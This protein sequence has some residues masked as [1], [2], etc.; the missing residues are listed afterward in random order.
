MSAPYYTC[1]V[2]G[3]TLS[4]SKTWG[5]LDKL[6]IDYDNDTEIISLQSKLETYYFYNTHFHL[7]K[8]VLTNDGA[9]IMNFQY[10]N[11]DG[12][13]Y[14]IKFYYSYMTKKWSLLS[15]GYGIK[16]DLLKINI[17]TDEEKIDR[18]L[19]QM[20]NGLKLH[21]MKQLNKEH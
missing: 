12:E 6:K 3:S 18:V 15:V 17:K 21:L 2:C 8:I 10:G 7:E 16:D 11:R 14:K 19:T 20:W 13:N 9:V 4:V 1:N 5:V